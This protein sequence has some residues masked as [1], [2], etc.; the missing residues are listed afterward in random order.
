MQALFKLMTAGGTSG[1]REVYMDVTQV[2]RVGEAVLWL[3]S[4]AEDG[5]PLSPTAVD[6]GGQI[7]DTETPYTVASVAWVIGPKTPAYPDAD[8]GLVVIQLDPVDTSAP[9]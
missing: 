6:H 5:T 3:D 7:N 9:T 4:E 8:H 1:C 2:P